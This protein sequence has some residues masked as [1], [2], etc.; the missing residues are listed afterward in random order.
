MKVVGEPMPGVL[1][2]ETPVYRDMRG[3]FM[4]CHHKQKLAALGIA[5]EFVQDNVSCSRAG[6]VRGLHFQLPNPQGKLVYPLKGCIYDV[7]VDVRRSSER[8]GAWAGVELREGDGRFLW[9]PPS[10]AHGFQALSDDTIVLYKVTDVWNPAAEHAI[11]W[12]DPKLGIAWPL[13]DA[14]LSP[15]DA[16][17]PCLEE[18][19][20]LPA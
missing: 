10:F 12:N 4:E 13:P 3:Y 9:I 1:L 8:F 5:A 18:L 20:S 15:K 6:T 7:V 19:Q 11:R 14:V 2:V 16:A 17:A